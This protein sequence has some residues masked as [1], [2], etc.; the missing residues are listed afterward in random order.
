M[1]NWKKVI[2]SGSDAALNSLE[3]TSHLTASG[4]I[5]PTSDGTDGQAITTDAAGNLT[6]GN[7]GFA[8]E[9][10]KVTFEVKNGDTGTLAK[11][12]PVHITSMT[13][14]TAIV[15]A[16]SASVASKMPSHGI[17]NQQLTVGSDGFATILGQV[18]GVNTSTFSPGDTVYVGSSGGYTNVKPTGSTNLIQN[19]G[20]IKKVDA[21]NGTGEIFGSGRTN[22]V[23]N[24]PT[25]KIWVGNDYTVTSSVVHL[26]EPNSRLG[27]NTNTP[28]QALD[29]L[30]SANISGSLIID[31]PSYSG[32][33][34]ISQIGNNQ[35]RFTNS[36][37]G[38]YMTVGGTNTVQ[39]NDQRLKSLGRGLELDATIS[40]TP[41]QVGTAGVGTGKGLTV[42]NSTSNYNVGIGSNAPTAKLNIVG[43][44]TTSAT[45]ALLIEDS[46]GTDLLEVNDQG[47][48][49]IPNGSLSLNG[50]TNTETFNLLGNM[51][52]DGSGTISAG[53]VG[54]N[55]TLQA[56]SANIAIG[57]PNAADI[58]IT[59]GVSGSF[60]GSFA[61]DGT[62]LTGITAEWDG[63]H[64]GDAEI[65]GSLIVSGSG[66]GLEVGG[67][68]TVNDGNRL[69]IKS[70]GG[71][72]TG[73]IE[74]SSYNA[75]V[76]LGL[77][78]TFTSARK[79]IIN[80]G[81]DQRWEFGGNS[82]AASDNIIAPGGG[83]TESSIY[84][85]HEGNIGFFTRGSTTFA[86]VMQLFDRTDNNNHGVKLIYKSGGSYSDGLMLDNTGNVGIGQTSPTARL[87][88]KGSGATSA[89][90]A[91]L[92]ENSSG[93]DLLQIRDDGHA[94]FNA[95][96]ET[97]NIKTS[98]AKISYINT[99]NNS[100]SVALTDGTDGSINFLN[101]V[102]IGVTNPSEKLEVAGNISGSGNVNIVGD[103]TASAFVG[104][105]SA[106]T[107]ITAEWD[108]SHN[109]DAEITGSLIVSGS[110]A[111]LTVT[112]DVGIGTSSPTVKLDVVSDGVTSA[113]FTNSNA[114]THIFDTTSGEVRFQMTTG[115]SGNTYGLSTYYGGK[116]AFNVAGTI[117]FLSDGSGNTT[118]GNSTTSLGARVGIKGSGATSATT[119]LLVE[120]SSGT[121]LLK[122]ED[123]GN[124]G[125]GTSTPLARTHIRGS[126]SGA[127]AV[128]NGTLIIE[129]GSAP[130]IQILSANSQTQS[131]KF[132]DPQDGDVG[133]I[134]YSHNTDDMKF[135]T[136]AGERMVIDSSGNVGIGTTSP[137]LQS[138]GTGLHINATTSSELKF[139]N[140]TTGVGAGN[141]TALVSNSNDFTINN[142]QA[143]T[144]R[145]GTDNTERIR[146]TSSGNVGIGTTSPTAKLDVEGDINVTNA[147]ISNQENTDI[148]TGTEVVAT[149]AIATYTAGFFDFVIKKGTNVRSGTIYACHDGTSVVHTE[150]TTI[151]LG[152][153]SDVDLAVD[154]SGGDMRLTA[155]V[156][157]DDWSVKSLVRGL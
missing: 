126:N 22:D 48:V 135:F 149:L 33:H 24:L 113:K 123:G 7:P 142:R 97:N 132:G 106:L 118:F 77:T 18:T 129:Q 16:A 44:G 121:D 1:P 10:E 98:V 96:V 51:F 150:T 127:T 137:A 53:G 152:D 3:I 128:A 79:I 145:L 59:G 100:Y 111:D 73:Y 109:G 70:T 103:V 101:N 27:I 66:V 20:V 35:F 71:T 147:N 157:S 105:G 131:I 119:A 148:D 130:S 68:I 12:T 13:G 64:N 104:D 67:D 89:T 143:G 144:I 4:L 117:A 107:N 31:N 55:L 139:T 93:T 136:G 102:G 58:T 34:T 112:G 151:D 108:G 17:L 91:L 6:F 99:F 30:G 40:S 65:T 115:Y 8:D 78:T 36:G 138:G 47:N 155:T 46:S 32:T 50:A 116:M 54:N 95:G 21:S 43:N 92:V 28:N 29:V 60:S 37:I 134:T 38:A 140:S 81:T 90:D 25:G 153:T 56:Q 69:N 124:V 49:T 94:I 14:G 146:I 125:I 86:N 45:T 88:V 84:A 120:N 87:N 80:D 15:V 85:G 114:S 72:Y 74:K 57:Y 110:S 41:L 141:G 75:T 122:I 5:Y 23:P 83:Y 63:S 62:N 2:I 76:S 19:L 39:I 156:A 82:T 11:G 133:R 61:G 9:A 42:L 26:D 52:F 154:I